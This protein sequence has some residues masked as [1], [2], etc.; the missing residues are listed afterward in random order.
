MVQA[1]SKTRMPVEMRILK[2]SVAVQ[3]PQELQV[4]WTRGK[5]KVATDK[6]TAK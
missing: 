4:E 3:E 6:K 2:A 1:S 5:Q